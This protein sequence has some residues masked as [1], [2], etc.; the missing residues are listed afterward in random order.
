MAKKII[1]ALAAIAA[2]LVLFW[3]YAGGFSKPSP[4]NQVKAGPW[5]VAY[6]R[7]TGPYKMVGKILDQLDRELQAEGIQTNRFGG[8][9]YDRPEIAGNDNCRSDA[10]AIITSE[11]AAKLKGHKVLQVRRIERRDYLATTF[12]FRGMLSVIAGISKV[13]P[14]Y[15]EYWQAHHLPE[16]QYKVAGFEND[17]A[18]ELYGP[19][20][21]FYYMTLNSGDKN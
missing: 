9:F 19:K 20:K 17:Y 2:A 10:I 4:L 3:A 18:I 13:Y 6:I 14:L 12:P 11:Q 16:Y 5:D 1:L 21:I 15:R 8:V 7:H